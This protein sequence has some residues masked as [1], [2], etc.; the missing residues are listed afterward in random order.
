[1]KIRGFRIELGEIESVLNT[2]PQIR[3]AVVIVREDIPGDKRLVAYLVTSDESI[4]TSELRHF[5]KQKLPQYMVP[6]A[7]V[8]LE[9]LP[10][11]ANGKVYRH[12]LPVPDHTSQE[13]SSTFVVTQ[14]QLESHLSK[15]WEQVLGIKPIGIKDNFFDLGGNSLQAVNLFTQIK[16]I[17]GKN[18][19]L[20]TLFQSGTVAEI[21][22]I[23][24]Q[25]E[26]LAPWES[27]V[28][29]QPDGNKPPLFYM[30]AGGGNLLVYRDLAYSLGL[31]QPVYGLQPRGLDGKYA[32]HNRIEEM[33]AH[34]LAQIR[35]IQ[36]NGPYF[37]AGL[38]T[39][40]NIAWEIAQRLH[41]QGEKV[42]LLALFDS[43]APGYYQLLPPLPR[44]FSVLNW[45]MFD[46]LRRLSRLPLKV[47]VKLTKL[48]IKQTS[49]KILERLGIVKRVLD[50]DQKIHKEHVQRQTRF[51]LAKYK[52]NSSNINSW[53]KW[54]NSLVIFLLKY[55]SHSYYANI[56]AGAM[57]RNALSSLPEELQKV[58]QANRQAH[59]AYVPQVYPGRVILFQAS[60]RPPGFYYD[61]Q[62]GWGNLAAG[63]IEIYKI[64]GTHTSIMKSPVLAK[65][66][67]ICLDKAQANQTNNHSL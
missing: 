8:R 18:L 22:Q 28:V 36:P 15:I 13:P 48:G 62:L 2:N 59:Q 40:G 34:Y 43:N 31:D 53:E 25:K 30:H 50:E 21:A 10:L 37:L 57:A 54:L 67:K 58:Q 52:S 7:F 23:I 66:L 29:I 46:F 6:S 32:P 60:E 38:S 3:Q 51:R 17:F 56:F 5:L 42:A 1:M 65:K 63:G 61:P 9:N 64:P 12:A 14:D 4:T 44:L 35:L 55:S 47:V 41:A 27:L 20:A 19:P 39:G 11:T 49:I 16:K 24:R 45:V 26:W 33:A